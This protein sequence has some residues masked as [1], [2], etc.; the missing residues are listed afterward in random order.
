MRNITKNC[1]DWRSTEL[2]LTSER[3]A[4]KSIDRLIECYMK[5]SGIYLES[6]RILPSG[7]VAIAYTDADCILTYDIYSGKSLRA[8]RM[9]KT[10]KTSVY[11]GAR[12]SH[13]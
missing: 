12:I 8:C 10:A 11:L 9:I 7:R 2:A 5:P 4:K 6:V 1:F 13:I 3:F